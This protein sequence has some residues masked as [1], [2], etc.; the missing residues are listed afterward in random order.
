VLN[1]ARVLVLAA[2][3]ASLSGCVVLAAAGAGVLAHDEATEKDGEFDPLEKVGRE[4]G[5]YDDDKD[6]RKR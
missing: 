2:A 3:S 6:S 1:I 5:V 4:V